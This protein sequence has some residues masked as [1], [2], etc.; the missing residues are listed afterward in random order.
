MSD[1]AKGD[2]WVVIK[3]NGRPYQASWHED[4]SIFVLE[5]CNRGHW[6]PIAEWMPIPEE[7]F[8][9]VPRCPVCGAK[10]DISTINLAITCECA[11]S[12]TCCRPE[13]VNYDVDPWFDNEFIRSARYEVAA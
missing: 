13:I 1:E 9:M 7:E 11:H 3:I 4:L 8:P 12:S 10:A 5:Y 2:A 6:G